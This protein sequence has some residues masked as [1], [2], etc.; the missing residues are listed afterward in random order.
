MCVSE[1]IINRI[2]EKR[3]FLFSLTKCIGVDLAL[4]VFLAE[5]VGK[6]RVFQVIE[7]Y[8]FILK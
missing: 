8:L 2:D 7:M 5:N 6:G 1:W 4:K 3:I